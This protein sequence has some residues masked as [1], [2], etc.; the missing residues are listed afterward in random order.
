MGLI[1]N[2]EWRKQ[3]RETFARRASDVYLSPFGG[4]GEMSGMMIMSILKD[5]R[6]NLYNREVL[7]NRKSENILEEEF[8]RAIRKYV[9]HKK[10]F[11]EKFFSIIC[12]PFEIVRWI[13]KWIVKILSWIGIAVFAIAIIGVLVNIVVSIIK[14][15]C[16]IIF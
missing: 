1:S 15:I 9:L 4:F 10:S 6:D 12:K 8:Q 11:G 3:C 5:T 16:S 2:W 13:V 14:F 7:W